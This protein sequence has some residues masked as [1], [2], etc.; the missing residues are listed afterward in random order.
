MCLFL[1]TLLFLWLV[2]ME[3]KVEQSY[4]KYFTQTKSREIF[5]ESISFPRVYGSLAN[6]DALDVSNYDKMTKYT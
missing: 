1:E 3:L 2:F 5:L 6:V 4:L